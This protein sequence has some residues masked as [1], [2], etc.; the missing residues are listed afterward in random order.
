VAEACSRLLT[1]PIVKHAEPDQERSLASVNDPDFGEQWYLSNTGQRVNG[2]RG[3]SG[4][5]IRWLSARAR[6][7][8]QQVIRV[9]VIDSGVAFL[10]PDL[11]LQGYDNG[12]EIINGVDDDKNDFVD[13]YSGYDFYSLDTLA[14]D[15]NGHGT[16]VA[17][18]IGATIDNG[19]G[20][21]GVTDSVEIMPYR[22][23]DQFARGGAPK[24][25]I[26]STGISDVLAS[27]AHAVEGGAKILN[28]S[29]GGGDPSELEALAYDEL[30]DYGVLAII[31][32]GNGGD[33]GESDDNDI[34]PTY[35]ASY[36]SP[37]I[38][39]VAAQDRTGGLSSFS[40]FGLVSVD[41][42]APGTD[43]YGPDVSRQ[44]VYFQDFENGAGG[45]TTGSSAGDESGLAWVLESLSGN[46]LLRDRFFSGPTTY[47]PNTDIWVTSPFIDLSNVQGARLEFESYRDL[48]DDCLILE[49]SDNGN[50]W[51]AYEY[52][53]NTVNE[54]FSSEPMDI[55]DLDGLSGYI[56]FRLITDYSVQGT[57]VLIDDVRISG[58]DDFDANNPQY[59]HNDGTSFAAPV[60]TGVAAMV[61]SHRPDLTASQVRE[62][63][64]LSARPVAA[65]GGRVATGGMV[66]ANAALIRAE[67]FPKKAQTIFFPQIPTQSFDPLNEVVLSASSSSGLTEI[68]Y[69]VVSGPGYIIGDFLFAS[70]PGRVVVRADQSGNLSYSAN[71]ATQTIVFMGSQSISF[72]PPL[73]KTFGDPD[74]MLSA[75]ASSGLP[76][77]FM[78]VSGPATLNGSVLRLTGAGTV[79]IRVSQAG[80]ANYFAAEPI[81]RTIT[82]S[83]ATQTITFVTPSN[84][85][86]GDGPIT[87][88]A[89]SS[90]GLPVTFKVDSGQATLTGSTL[91]FTGAGPVVISANQPGNSNYNPADIVFKGIGVS[92]ASQTITF[93]PPSS[94][95]FGGSATNLSAA[96]TSNLPVA[97]TVVSGPGTI[98]GSLLTVTG[99]GS[100]LIRSI[101][102]GDANYNAAAPVERTITVA[103]A[104]QNIM[105]APIADRTFNPS[106]NT[107]TL[108]AS[109][110]SGLSPVTYTVT[111][112]PA[113]VSGNTLT[114]AG[115]GSVTVQASQAG[116]AD[117][118]AASASRT[119]NVAKAQQTIAFNPTGSVTLGDAPLVLSSSATS[120]LPVAFTLISGPATLTGST[121]TTTGAGSVVIRAT[122][123]GDANYNAATPIDR[124]ITVAAASQTIT[125][126]PIADRTYNPSAN[127]LTLAASASSG[128]SSV[129]FSVTG[130][131]ATVSGNT[132]TITGA[133]SVTVQASQA[134]N[135]NYGAA[136]ASR[137][138]NVA[139]ASQ[140]VAFNP[141]ASASFG[142]APL[143]LAATA[144]SGFPVAFTLVSGPATLSGSTLILTG[145]GSVIVRATQAG[146]ANYNA[147]SPID[148]TIT[149]TAASQT[150]TFTPIAD[151]TYNPSANA[152]TLSASSS[153]GLAVN[154]SVT[155]GPAT[156]SGNT[157]TITGAGSVTVQASQTG[158]SDYALASVARTFSVAKATQTIFFTAPPSATFGDAPITLSATSSSGLPVIFNVASGPA[159]L[160][161]STL[162]ITGAGSVV[163]SA[164]QPGNGN[165]SAA[166]SVSQGIS[167]SKA[168]QSI[169]FNPP[170]SVPFGGS[171]TNLSASASSGLPVA[172][173]VVSGPGSLTGS[174]LVISGTGSVVVRATQTGGA[175]Y[176]AATPIDRTITVAAASQ[177]ITFAPIAN[178]TYNPSANTLTL[179]ASASS[180]LSSVTF[181]V[182]GGPA[183]VSGNTLT[184]T[185]AGSVTVQASQAGNANY[186]AASASQTFTV[187]K[188][189]QT[190]AFNAP[191]SATYGNAPLALSATADSGLPV[192]LSVSSGPGSVTGSTLSLTGAGIVGITATQPGNANYNPAVAV[193]KT[194]SVGKAPLTISA[195]NVSRVVGAANP[196]LPLSYVGLVGADTPATALSLAPVAATKATAKSAPG[197]YP[198]TL[199]GGASANY[200]LTLVPGTL[201]VVGFGGTYEALLVTGGRFPVG[202]LTV[203]I[204]PTALSYTGTLTLAR[205]AKSIPVASTSKSPGTTAFVGSTDSANAAANWTRTT[206]GLDALELALTVSADGTLAGS[207]DRNG[208][209]FA[210]LAHGARQRTFAKGQ[211]A[212]G[213]GANTLALHPAYT[214]SDS[215]GS[216]PSSSLPAPRSSP[217]GSGFS[218]APIAPTTGVMTLKGFTADGSPL[219]ATLKPTLD[220]TYLLWVNPYGTRTESF[221]AGALPLQAH[222]ETT[223]F[224]GRAYISRN[225]GLLTWQKAA[226]PANTAT[227]KLDKSYRAGFGPLGVEVSLDPWLPPSARAVGAIPAGTLAQR[228]GLAANITS[229][230]AL[231]IAHG[232]DA[233]DLGARQ[234]L[235]PFAATLSPAGV[236][237][238]TNAA[239][240]AWTIKITPATGAFT[241]TFTL[242]DPAPT[243]AKPS[244]TVDRKVTFSGVLRQAPSGDNEVATG[245]FLVPGFPVPKGSAPTEQ[246]SGEIRFSAP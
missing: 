187:A 186:G 117:Y 106:A 219:T 20:V 112:G 75:T 16:L 54:A 36:S 140:T 167:V 42:A 204:P 232:P 132:L 134:G 169:L 239:A 236:L 32:A 129:T 240:T 101:Q 30:V 63:I 209:P 113:T 2:K 23:F 68:T 224:P 52:Y 166:E 44:I 213:A 185:G 189:S 135:A 130:G 22:V 160:T 147:A 136:S 212:P 233:L 215:E 123:A 53:Y 142:D 228:L 66:D 96:A 76:V 243:P 237:T 172:F 88:S 157:L 203:T 47:R 230:G 168:A 170:A 73:N 154:F 103:N 217:L 218:T 41:I 206:N 226:L 67:S 5:D 156:I 159:I 79:T 7:Q 188:A 207:L 31:A 37:A 93:N 39:A 128:L 59:Q 125:F 227:A 102:T 61:W 146:D 116:N 56:R 9:A 78:V 83:K 195:K 62:A 194:I 131:P 40:N 57:G 99:P 127:T 191:F 89:T 197:S 115:A 152:L 4:I 69:S 90:S 13:D 12:A 71:F 196:S 241:G 208:E 231:N 77:S 19:I 11:I 97:F 150:I 223:R 199:S 210:T 120:G 225:A 176:S 51:L 181:S 148:R 24:F 175:N 26:G 104:P 114:I 87:L 151:R 229:S 244:A 193:P 6:H 86:F 138:F 58:I 1:E 17:G 246:P 111:S 91:T 163:I 171:A 84:A 38:I 18:I 15:Q 3:P 238:A 144:T 29:L 8:P 216:T 80:D 245:F 108:S 98:T 82:I 153:S 119:F 201:T 48:A 173:S 105:F 183:T 121:L 158:N 190:I 192:T 139:K 174:S 72:L 10:H 179:A 85:T 137:T 109:A 65:L 184:I 220:D 165:Y 33:D 145:A 205:E 94:V 50:E 14:L 122:Q 178:R 211:T 143:T 182:T 162:T 35:P 235:L 124:T 100:I 25:Q 74:F 81:G 107:L 155:S 161:G 141:P 64:L 202:K 118:G 28:L 221:L 242:R 55:S 27:V 198:I 110:S 95:P 214:L 180:G 60:V 34:L 234:T 177:T 126:A 43:I 49:V 164:T 21:A 45:W 133:G 149:V 92:K 200:S 46:T 222:P 70:A